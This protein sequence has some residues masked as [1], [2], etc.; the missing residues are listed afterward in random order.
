MLSGQS[1]YMWPFIRQPRQVLVSA[2]VAFVGWRAACGGCFLLNRRCPA[3]A[4]FDCVGLAVMSSARMKTDWRSLPPAIFVL[5][6]FHPD[7]TDQA[8]CNV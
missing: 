8:A 7:A 6:V 2:V 5:A 1:R 3:V 4:G